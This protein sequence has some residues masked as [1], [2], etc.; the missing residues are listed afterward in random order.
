MRFDHGIY[1]QFDSSFAIPS[2]SF[3]EIVGGEAALNIPRPFKPET[4]EKIYLTR[5][6]KIETI[7]I[8]GQELYIGEVEDLADAILL[9]REQRISLDDSRANV[10]VIRALLE[11]ART[12]K[13]VSV[14]LLDRTASLD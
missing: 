10:A 2:H 1:A 9:G 11:S 12:G 3:I 13:P 4:D 7:K 6:E 5:G 8:K 14:S